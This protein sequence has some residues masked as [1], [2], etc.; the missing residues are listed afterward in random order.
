MYICQLD[1]IV[2][3]EIYEQLSSFLDAADV[4]IAMDSKYD[5]VKYLL[6]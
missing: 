1:P 5:D 2:Q 3:Q 6:E 4:A